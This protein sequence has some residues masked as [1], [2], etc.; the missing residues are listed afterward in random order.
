MGV[1]SV[2]AY[3]DACILIYLVEDRIHWSDPIRQR[4]QPEHSPLPTLVFT[5]LTRLECRLQPLKTG[6]TLAL[7]AFDQLFATS[8][9]GYQALD[10]P[11]FESATQL[12]AQY[13]LKTPDAL[14]LA[15]ALQAGCDEFWTNDQRL[16]KAA[17]NRLRIVTFE[18]TS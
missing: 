4:L 18:S 6:N 9:Y 2:R 12:R 15:A 11:V 10:R 1:A 14:H 17:Q 8:G 16:A 3:P 5:E 13:G 7:N